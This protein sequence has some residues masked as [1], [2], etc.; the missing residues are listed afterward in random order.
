MSE[1][2]NEAASGDNLL[3][4]ESAVQSD[5]MESLPEDMRS[6][7]N[8]KRFEKFVD[9]DQFNIGKV[10]KSYD[11]MERGYS[12][13]IQLPKEDWTEDDYES[14][15][16]KLGRPESSDKYDIRKPEMPEG[17][18]YNEDLEQSF[19]ER[20]FSAGLNGKQVQ[21]LIDWQAE[22]ISAESSNININEAT[23]K[24]RAEEVLKQEWPGQ[25]YESKL[26]L[27]RR[28]AKNL[29]DEDFIKMINNKGL[30]NEP[31]LIKNLAKI[32]S[33][34]SES[35]VGKDRETFSFG[36][37]KNTA[38]LEINEIMN[39]RDHKYHQAYWDTT[40]PQHKEANE[41][42][43]QLYSMRYSDAE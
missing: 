18:P 10:L 12:D 28:T 37:D 14:F 30:A 15:Y 1:E 43:N 26:G 8:R 25:E 31:T 16:K 22:Q 32:G 24:A 5:W 7:D 33:L 6:D 17:Y 41:Y 35:K 42:M 19:K 20:A 29:F 38:S 23:E 13:R 36:H 4:E 9:N 40:D 11:H 39:S 34:L 27:A 2:T 3:G 21:E